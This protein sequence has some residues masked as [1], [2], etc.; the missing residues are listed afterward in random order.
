MEYFDSDVLVKAIVRQDESKHQISQDLISNSLQN[1]GFLISTL[2]IQEVGYVLARL[3]I[4]GKQIEENLK[5]F[6]AQKVA[7]IEKSHIERALDI[8]K[9]LGYKN[10]NDCIHTALAESWGCERF[11]TYNDADYKRIKRTSSLNFK[12]LS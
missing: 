7:T 2:V 10:I 11:Y 1:G 6:L 3:D 9:L 8:A 12:I 5:F 4:P